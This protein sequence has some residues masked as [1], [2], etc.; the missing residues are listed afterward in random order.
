[1]TDKELLDWLERTELMQKATPW[2]VLYDGRSRQWVV[3]DSAGPLYYRT[4]LRE[5]LELCTA[6]AQL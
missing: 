1:M 3:R 2:R 5:A 4:T 6:H